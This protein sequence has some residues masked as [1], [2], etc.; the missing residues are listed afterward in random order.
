MFIELNLWF[1]FA[2]CMS[3]MGSKESV[4]VTKPNPDTSTVQIRDHKKITL[5]PC[6]DSTKSGI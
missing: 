5:K 1:T 4:I 3:A 2:I 6:N